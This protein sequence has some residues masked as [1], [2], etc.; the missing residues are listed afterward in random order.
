MMSEVE[1]LD[2]L[3][4]YNVKPNP[5]I[6]SSLT[7]ASQFVCRKCGEKKT[8]HDFHK[9]AKTVSGYEY[10]CIQCRKLAHKVTR[11]D[12]GDR[13]WG[14][15]TTQTVENIRMSEQRSYGDYRYDSVPMKPVPIRGSVPAW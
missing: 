3:K 6:M 15:T 4:K 13:D 8:E 7:G 10:T 14:C 5:K 9:S 12:T 11:R 2:F 1:A